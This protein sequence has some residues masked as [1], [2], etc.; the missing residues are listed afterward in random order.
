MNIKILGSGCEKCRT[1]Y[2]MTCEIVQK[3][4]LQATVEKVEEKEQIMVYG[5]ARTPALV[6]DGEVKLAGVLPDME[7]LSSII[8]G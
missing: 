4:E 7:Q 6:I 2:Q 3:S 5:V 8:L 1:L